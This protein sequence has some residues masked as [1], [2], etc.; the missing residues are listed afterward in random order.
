[1]KKDYNSLGYSNFDEYP[2]LVY[3]TVFLINGK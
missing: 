3:G 1:M 2:H